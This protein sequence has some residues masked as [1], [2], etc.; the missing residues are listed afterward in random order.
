MQQAGTYDHGVQTSSGEARS[1]N[2][3][4]SSGELALK[5]G[6]DLDGSVG[7][8]RAIVESLG[9]CTDGSDSAGSD[10]EH[11]RGTHFD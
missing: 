6:L 10:S 5:V 1:A 9:D 8:G 7:L 3:T 4:C 11:G 2:K